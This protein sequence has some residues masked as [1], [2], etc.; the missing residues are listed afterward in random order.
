M[1]NHIYLNAKVGALTKTP[2]QEQTPK[3]HGRL[4]LGGTPTFSRSLILQLTWAVGRL[5][6]RDLSHQASNQNRLTSAGAWCTLGVPKLLAIS[7]SCIKSGR[8]AG[9]AAIA[10][11]ANTTRDATI[12]QGKVIVDDTED[13]APA[14][15]KRWAYFVTCG[16]HLTIYSALLWWRRETMKFS[17]IAAGVSPRAVE[18]NKQ[19]RQ[20]RRHWTKQV[21]AVR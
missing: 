6:S 8:A 12:I 9:A 2:W 15:R 7:A 4:P 16:S 18:E 5:V 19:N 11:L 10:L 3:R 21:A 17:G 20:R 13:D 14:S 1:T